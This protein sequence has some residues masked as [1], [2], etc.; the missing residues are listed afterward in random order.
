[1]AQPE[2]ETES[3]TSNPQ[4]TASD[5]GDGRGNRRSSLDAQI[6]GEKIRSFA[7][8]GADAAKQGLD[9]ALG[10]VRNS[11]RAGLMAEEQLANTNRWMTQRTSEFW[12]ASLAPLFN[13]Q[14]EAIKLVEQAWSQTPRLFGFPGAIA[15]RPL[16]SLPFAP[17]FGLPPADLKETNDGYTLRVELPGLADGDLDLTIRGD[18]LAICAEK[19]DDQGD[20]PT[21]PWIS[22]RRFGRFDRTFTL[23]HDVDRGRISA[24]VQNGVLDIALP[25]TPAAL[26]AATRI[27]VTV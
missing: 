6:T 4:T 14:L 23:P 11:A 15:A 2:Q 16:A 5:H 12:R 3:T 27:Q 20:D 1:M 8:L 7:N 18:T 10:A 21:V 22:E 19:R 25:K 9:P 13:M 26:E 17:L 24:H